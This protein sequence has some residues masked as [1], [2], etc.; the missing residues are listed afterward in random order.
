MVDDAKSWQKEEEDDQHYR[1][2]KKPRNYATWK[3]SR[4]LRWKGRVD[5]TMTIPKDPG[6]AG[7]AVSRFLAIG[8]GG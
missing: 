6:T 1:G 4:Q 8:F 3:E 2:T 7:N 5:A